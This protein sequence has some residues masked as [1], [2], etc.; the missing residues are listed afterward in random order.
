MLQHGQGQAAIVGRWVDNAAV[1]QLA[2]L[3]RCLHLLEELGLD[4]LQLLCVVGHAYMGVVLVPIM[5]LAGPTKTPHQFGFKAGDTHLVV[6]DASEKLTAFDFH[7]TRL[8]AIPC[9]ARGQGA[10]TEW[11]S[12]NTDTPPG[13]YKVGSVWRDYDRLGDKPG[14]QPDLMPYGW[15]TL[16]L[17]E[18]EEQERRYGRAGIAI[19]GGGSGLGW[20]GCWQPRQALLPT[21]GCVRVHNADLRDKIVLL[22]TTGTVFVSVYQEKA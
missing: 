16:D 17:V 8:F 6:N 22:L 18:L 13:L 11:K 14:F 15:Y 9:L 21:H 7:G 2:G 19:H 1:L 20:P 4:L 10:D 12:P 3:Q 5:A